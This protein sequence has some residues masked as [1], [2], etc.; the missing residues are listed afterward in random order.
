MYQVVF[1]NGFIGGKDRVVEEF[2]DPDAAK[3]YAKRARK[4]L[5]PGERKYYKCTYLVKKVSK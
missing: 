4:T 2:T 5:S 1:I 3:E